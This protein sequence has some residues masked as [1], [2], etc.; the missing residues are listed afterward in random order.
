[1]SLQLVI[2]S[3]IACAARASDW[4]A[5]ASCSCCSCSSPNNPARPPVIPL[6][7]A[8]IPLKPAVKAS[9]IVPSILASS[10]LCGSSRVILLPKRSISWGSACSSDKR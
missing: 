3:S 6:P 5:N 1:M 9:G 7:V 8:C 10:S 2:L 4:R